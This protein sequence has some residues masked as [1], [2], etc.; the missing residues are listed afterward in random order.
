MRPALFW[1]ITWH[2][3]LIVYQCFRTTY[4]S[5]RKKERN[6]ERKK[7]RKIDRQTDRQTDL[8]V[9]NPVEFQWET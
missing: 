4:Q 9:L 1:D 3:V 6:K 5:H 2:R 7:E 8:N